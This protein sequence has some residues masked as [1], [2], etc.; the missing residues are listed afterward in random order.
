MI[1]EAVQAQVR[2]ITPSALTTGLRAIRS[3]P[4]LPCW[5]LLTARGWRK[6]CYYDP[7]FIYVFIYYFKN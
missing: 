5:V 2:A 7:H 6:G 4:A 1:L 3:S